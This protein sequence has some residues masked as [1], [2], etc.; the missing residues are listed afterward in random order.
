MPGTSCLTATGSGAA[1]GPSRPLSP[2]LVGARAELRPVS[3]IGPAV[4]AGRAARARDAAWKQSAF[5]HVEISSKGR[6]AVELDPP[7]MAW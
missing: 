1:V 6:A 5:S 7:G 3:C 4:A 2:T